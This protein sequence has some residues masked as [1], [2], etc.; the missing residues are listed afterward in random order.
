MADAAARLNADRL[1]AIVDRGA[2]ELAL[3]E[4]GED[5][6]RLVTER[7]PHLFASVPLFVSSTR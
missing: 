5:F 2:L 7:C 1:S 3:R 6:F 4:Q